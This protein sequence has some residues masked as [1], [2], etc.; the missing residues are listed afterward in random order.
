MIEWCWSEI[1]KNPTVTLDIIQ[2]FS[3]KPWNINSILKNS[4]I[5]LNQLLKIQTLKS[6]VTIYLLLI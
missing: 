1:S 5:T 4:N 6:N 3:D 2:R